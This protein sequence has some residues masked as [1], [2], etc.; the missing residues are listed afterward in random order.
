MARHLVCADSMS[1]NAVATRDAGR[2]GAVLRPEGGAFSLLPRL[3]VR[4]GRNGMTTT[5]GAML[6]AHPGDRLDEGPVSRSGSTRTKRSRCG[7]WTGRG[8]RP[9]RCHDLP[10]MLHRDLM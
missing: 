3:V 7:C 1:L 9:G 8:Y 6:A 2:E 10:G 4:V 5:R